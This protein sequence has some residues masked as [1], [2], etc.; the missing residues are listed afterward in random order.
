MASNKCV[1]IAHT[2]NVYQVETV[3][4]HILKWTKPL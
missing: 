3:Q 1:N 2:V 4:T